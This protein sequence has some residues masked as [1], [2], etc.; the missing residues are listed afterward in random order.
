MICYY[1]RFTY[2]TLTYNTA[3]TPQMWLIGALG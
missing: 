1:F 3:H 2:L